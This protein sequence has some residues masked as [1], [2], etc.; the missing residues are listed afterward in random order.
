M[1]GIV[2]ATYKTQTMKHG[3]FSWRALPNQL[4]LWLILF[5]QKVLSAALPRV[6][7]FTPSCSQYGFQAFSAYPF[8]KA[9]WL[10]IRRIA[11]CHPFHRGGYDP[12]P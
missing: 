11:R 1:P 9:L 2:S 8:F 12:L 5:Y 6:C 7:R 4:M 3:A 10:T